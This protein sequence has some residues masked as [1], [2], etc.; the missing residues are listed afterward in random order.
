[1]REDI[2]VDEFEEVMEG[3]LLRLIRPSNDRWKIYDIA[4]RRLQH[5]AEL[6]ADELEGRGRHRPR[7]L[8]GLEVF[9][10]LIAQAW[11]AAPKSPS[12]AEFSSKFDGT[13]GSDGRSECA[14][15]SPASKFI[16][17]ASKYLQPPYMKGD[18]FEERHYTVQNCESV[19]DYVK[20]H[21]RGEKQGANS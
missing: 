1:V 2:C 13:W 3:R 14:P 20:G 5:G 12:V 15:K 19:M 16:C 10:R 9:T 17:E 8:V 6:A 21:R 4:L 7:E 18:F 11:I